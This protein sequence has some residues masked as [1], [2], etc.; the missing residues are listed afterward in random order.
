MALLRR[1]S[2]TGQ[3]GKDL[4]RLVRRGRDLE[5]LKALVRTLA[6]V[7]PLDPR[8]RDHAL[9]GRWR[10]SR[11]CHVEPDWVL[12]YTLDHDGLR[13]ERTGS[14]SDLFR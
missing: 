8:H 6:R 11:D 13:L 14:H 10:T 7:E 4:K 2:Q 12:I 3:F 9:T 5:K 1:V